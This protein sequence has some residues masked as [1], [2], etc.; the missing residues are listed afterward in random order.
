M[1]KIN[2][3]FIILVAGL[4]FPACDAVNLDEINP[5]TSVP[6]NGAINNLSSATAAVNGIYDELQMTNTNHLD[7][8]MGLAQIYSDE[9]IFTGTFPTRFEFHNLNVTTSN[10]TNASVFTEFYDI[11]NTSNNL[12]ELLPKVDDPT[13]SDAT[14]N[15]FLAEARFARALSYFYLTNYYGDIPLVLTPTREVGDVLSVPNN[16]QSEIYTQIVSDLQFAEA[17][18]TNSDTKRFTTTAATAFLARVYL[19]LEDWGNALSKAEQALGAGFDLTTFEYLAD[20]ILYLGFT[21]T[22]GNVL[23]FWYGPSELGGRHDIEPSPKFLTQ[24]ETGDLRR[25]K[26][27]DDSF[28][29]ATVPYVLK[30][31][32]FS[33]G[34]SGSATD[35]IMLIR[36]AE[37]VLIAAEAAAETGDFGKANGYYNQVRARAGLAAKT[38]DAGNFVDLILQ[39]RW[40][41][42]C[43]EGP[44]RFF[45]LRR[46]G[47]ATAEIDGYQ[48]CHDFWPIPQR[49][50]DRNPNLSQNNCCNC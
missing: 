12:L 16:A 25:D 11:I 19:Y 45:D 20:E 10:G 35:P 37:I 24:Y 4:I 39:E 14:R 30:Y 7:A 15:G 17:N 1:K 9:A 47:Q 48:S 8:Y 28:T 50:I 42:L 29:A 36:H 13:L 27:I 3:F 5:N 49:E 46:R 44:H 34:I 38:L 43:F 32:D 6:A 23:N 18:L 40:I 33:S 21:P 26:S 41:E 22:D 2:I 31:D